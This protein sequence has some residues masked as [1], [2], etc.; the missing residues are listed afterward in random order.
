MSEPT[1]LKPGEPVIPAA[2]PDDAGVAPV[3]VRAAEIERVVADGRAAELRGETWTPRPPFITEM[4]RIGH[5]ELMLE[6]RA[7]PADG[8]NLH[9]D[10]YEIYVVVDG[11]GT[12]L[13]GGSL[14]DPE[15]H[16]PNLS[17]RDCVDATPYRIAKGDVLII[18][19]NTV[20][21]VSETNGE[22]AVMSM[23]LPL[24]VTPPS[25]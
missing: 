5:F 13:L 11:E 4:L 6:S 20:H 1:A 23:H 12:M 14:V 9:E 15:R 2:H 10:Q 22:L 18:S 17:A 8:Y 19:P 21:G 25:H 24:P 7:K 16:G 3:I